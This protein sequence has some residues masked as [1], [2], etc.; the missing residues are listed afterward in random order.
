M[1]VTHVTTEVFNLARTNGPY[2]SE[3]LVDTGS[4]D[5]MAPAEE[6]EKIGIQK[7]WKSVYELANGEEVEY[8]LGFV[9]VAFMGQETVAQIIFG[10]RGT[11]PI[12]GVVVLENMGFVVDPGS[13]QLKKLG[14]RPLK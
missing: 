6:L 4:I 14:A 2:E 7:E 1:G 5:C 8:E 11:E 13:N 9:R 10:P 3:F 12:L